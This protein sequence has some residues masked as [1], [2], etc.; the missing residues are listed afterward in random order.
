MFLFFMMTKIREK[1]RDCQKLLFYE[2]KRG[3]K[4]Y[5]THPP[6]IPPSLSKRRGLGG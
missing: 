6:L 5:K 4:V 1:I 2:C 3:E